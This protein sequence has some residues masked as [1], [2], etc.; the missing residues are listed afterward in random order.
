MTGDFFQHCWYPYGYVP[1][2]PNTITI[3]TTTSSVSPL[4]VTPRTT[5]AVGQHHYVRAENPLFGSALLLYCEKCGD[6][7]EYPGDE[8]D[9]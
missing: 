9:E 5:C 6:V 1:Y 3:T 2:W 7:V 8:A 4:T